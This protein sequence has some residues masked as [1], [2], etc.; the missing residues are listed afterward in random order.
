MVIGFKEFLA[1]GNKKDPEAKERGYLAG[2]NKELRRVKSETGQDHVRIHHNG[3][4]YHITHAT[5]TTPGT[6]KSDFTLV[7]KDGRH[8]YLSHK[9]YTGKGDPSRHYQQLGGISKYKDHPSVQA[10]GDAVKQHHGGTAVGKGTIAKKLNMRSKRD[11]TLVRK[12]M[13]G[14]GHEEGGKRGPNAVHSIVHGTMTLHPKPGKKGTYEIHAPLIKHYTD[15][16][17]GHYMVYGRTAKS[18]KSA[19]NDLGLKHTR[20]LIGSSTSRKVSKWVKE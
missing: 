2:L 10:F 5:K 17:G 6:P 13:F 16:V 1:E 11:A 4:V 3:E 19:R 12:A 18:G 15:P 9:D 8:I 14:H 20:V 7:G